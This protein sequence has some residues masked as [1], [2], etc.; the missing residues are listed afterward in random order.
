MAPSARE[1]LSPGYMAPPV[2]LLDPQRKSWLLRGLSAEYLLI[3]GAD[4]TPEDDAARVP[5]SV[6]LWHLDGWLTHSPG[7][8]WALYE[9]LGGTE[10]LGLSRLGRS[11]EAQRLRQR[12]ERALRL[13]ELV[14]LTYERPRHAPLPFPEPVVEVEPEP[15]VPE[16]PPRPVAPAPVDTA[17][18]VRA[19]V[20]AAKEG[21][22]FCEEC[23]RAAAARRAA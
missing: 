16:A 8:A 3:R 14:V 15:P 20:Q 21:L 12:L 9:A 2:P 13:G 5:E 19:L 18:Q 23:A 22:P 7:S 11:A 10:P 4:L 17:A 6:A 1:L